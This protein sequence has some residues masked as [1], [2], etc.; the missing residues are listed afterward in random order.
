MTVDTRCSLFW[1]GVVCSFVLLFLLSVSTVVAGG[2]TCTIE[3][4]SCSEPAAQYLLLFKNDTGGYNNAHAELP[5]VGSYPYYLCCNSSD[6]AI[7]STCGT[8]FVFLSED[9]NAHVMDSEA[10]INW[11]YRFSA[12]DACISGDGTFVCTIVSGACP[13]NYT[14]FL[15][16]AATDGSN[17]TNAHVAECDFYDLNVCCYGN[18]APTQDTPIF[19][20]TFGTNLTTENLT[21]YNQSTSDVEG[22]PVKNIY[23][24]DEN[25]FYEYLDLPFEGR[26]AAV[27]DYSDFAGNIS[28]VG[29]TWNATGGF[30]GKGAYEFDGIDDYLKVSAGWTP[31]ALLNPFTVSV[32]IRSSSTEKS[33]I[34]YEGNALCNDA[35][36][37]TVEFYLL[38][39]GSLE[40]VLRMLDGSA[41]L[42]VGGSNL[43]DGAWHF[44]SFSWD[45]TSAMRLAVNGTV[46]G[47]NTAVVTS[48]GTMNWASLGAAFNCS[49]TVVGTPD[50]ENGEAYFLSDSVFP[51]GSAPSLQDRPTEYTVDEYAAIL[52]SD[53][54]E[55][56]YSTTDGAYYEVT[57]YSFTLPDASI[58][59]LLVIWDAYS[60]L[61]YYGEDVSLFLWNVTKGRWDMVDSSQLTTYPIHVVSVSAD[62][63]IDEAT[64]KTY[65][66][67]QSNGVLCACTAWANSA[68]TCGASNRWRQT[69]TCS[70]FNCAIQEQCTFS[71]CA[72]GL[73]LALYDVGISSE[74]LDEQLEFSEDSTGRSS[75]DPA[76]LDSAIADGKLYLY[77]PTRFLQGTND[78]RANQIYL[79][80]WINTLDPDPLTEEAIENLTRLFLAET[81]QTFFDQFSPSLKF[82]APARFDETIGPFYQ[83]ASA[84][85]V[86]LELL[87]A[88]TPLYDTI[89]MYCPV[90]MESYSADERARV[91]RFLFDALYG[92]SADEYI[93]AYYVTT[94]AYNRLAQ[95]SRQGCIPSSA[96]DD[97]AAV[98]V[99]RNKLITGTFS[100]WQVEGPA[101]LVFTGRAGFFRPE[102]VPIILS[103]R[104]SDGGWPAV[105]D[106]AGTNTHTTGLAVLALLG[107]K[108]QVL[109]QQPFPEGPF[110]EDGLWK[111]PAL[112]P[113][114]KEIIPLV[115]EEP[116]RT[117][118]VDYVGIG[119]PG[120][121]EPFN[122]T[123]DE[124]RIHAVVLS[125]AQLA[126]YGGNHPEIL[127]A[128][129]TDY[130][131]SWSC[132]VF[133]VDDWDAADYWQTGSITINSP[134]ATPTLT[135][136]VQG[137]SS[138][139]ERNITF[140]WISSF[141]PDVDS[142][143]SDF[144]LTQATCAD[145]YQENTS[146][147]SYTSG[148]LC[149][150]QVYWWTVRNCDIY[151]QCSDWA[152]AWNFT[153]ASVAGISFT[154]NNTDFGEMNIS[155]TDNTSDDSPAPFAVEN[156]GNVPL[157]VTI[158]AN[159][160]L[161]SSSGLGNSSFR[162][163]ARTADA[164]HYQSAQT[165]WTDVA[166][167]YTALFTNLK[168]FAELNNASID[169][170]VNVPND[171]APGAKEAVVSVQGEY[172]G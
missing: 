71:S 144:N 97:A 104:R 132:R 46:V 119:S 87:P 158:K 36:N 7:S 48:V 63:Y 156:T 138:V 5:S 64:N 67:V 91:T 92:V 13:T 111:V 75:F 164:A 101:M 59:N 77:D 83:E 60:T 69:R 74:I 168:Y 162:Y 121:G 163:A 150:D 131:T 57:N 170:L 125:T 40:G 149:V 8:P 14:C 33:T 152:T 16:M 24:F 98:V 117:L 23:L 42:V 159:D 32:W 6:N 140:E 55:A 30:D 10:R 124:V 49:N 134:P 133:P 18:V 160:D 120:I 41:S 80:K 65:V 56:S 68:C 139:F 127:A 39:N 26:Y 171:E 118:L 52:A 82:L 123:I 45:G 155:M 66:M 106:I 54:V 47:T 129:E 3:E 172:T 137:N 38:G 22:S 86:K 88:E 147:G 29:A 72:G 9:T 34:F 99:A 128:E 2:L 105:A 107:Y 169:I 116:H 151:D 165:S 44:V 79:L 145:D 95:M 109:E 141:D 136:P 135:Y 73:K 102:W 50:G 122:G 126:A 61:S 161:F 37:T 19:N 100:D 130:G 35:D 96:A 84:P 166:A 113:L 157:N 43:N 167:D 93:P 17:Q 114:N 4:S 53:D 11:S 85:P 1:S 153:I 148:E 76:E 146:I 31:L 15:S 28:S 103:N 81:D 110:F 70:P 78:D 12:Y 154:V 112:D 58:Q 94:H 62:D 25:S 20:S 142:M 51:A 143:T 90:I 108:Q 115:A 21:C 89:A 27:K